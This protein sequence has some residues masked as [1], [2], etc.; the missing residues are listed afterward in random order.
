MSETEK[1]QRTEEAT[2]RRL[3]EA[4]DKGQVAFS[5]EVVAA[6]TLA[7][8]VLVLILVGPALAENLAGLVTRGIEMTAL[9]GPGDLDSALSTEV[10]G[11]AMGSGLSAAAWVLLPLLLVATLAAYAQVGIRIS[12]K[13]VEIDVQKLSPA[14]GMK[15][16]FSARTT[17]RTGLALGKV[18]LVTTVMGVVAWLHV[19]H[20]VRLGASELGPVLLGLGQVAFRCTVAALFFIAVLSAFDFFFQRRQHKKDLRMSRKE[21]RDEQ[22]LTEGDPH[23]KARVRQVQRQMASRRMMADVP[24][25]TVV[26]TNPTHYAVALRY[27]EGGEAVGAPIVVAKGTDE[28]AQ[29]IKTIAREAGVHCYE[30]VPLARSLHA[31]VPLGEEVPED[32][33][34]AVAAVLSYVYRLKGVRVGA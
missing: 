18:L 6:A 5:G 21:L 13:T 33:Y 11:S 10:L 1:D 17:V 34:T 4:R 16:L 22:R 26:V 15:R 7:A 19:P 32:L 29:N 20:V 24:S 23:L 2:P 31:R 30:N 27:E 12:P 25:A 9:L 8:S 3:E 14:R 28:V